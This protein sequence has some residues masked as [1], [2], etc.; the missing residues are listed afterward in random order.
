MPDP[1]AKPEGVKPDEPKPQPEAK[2]EA[3]A[4]P[5]H[6][7]KASNLTPAGESTNPIVHSLLAELE[8]LRLNGDTEGADKIL[9]KLEE[10]GY[11]AG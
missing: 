2:P 4:E 5:K 10:L 8:G 1:K 7:V 6:Q 9:A 11:S 3:K